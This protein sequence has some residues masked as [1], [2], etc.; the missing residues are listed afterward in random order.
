MPTPQEDILKRYIGE[1]MTL[2]IID[3]SNIGGPVH[4]VTAHANNNVVW[5]GQTFSPFP[6]E[7]EGYEMNN[8]GSQPRP[9]IRVSNISKEFSQEVLSNDNYIN[10]KVTRIQ[11]LGQYL[12]TNKSLSIE[13]FY[14]A[15]KTSHTKQLI[16]FELQTPLGWE[17]ITLPKRK[18]LRAEFPGI[19]RYR[20]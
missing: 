7:S 2:Y 20:A 12:N 16:E 19:G 4:R 11:T 14:V 15:K 9:T 10:A 1:R 13:T 18:V 6:I 8:A 5:D 3:A 17:S